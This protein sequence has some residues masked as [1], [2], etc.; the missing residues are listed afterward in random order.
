MLAFLFTALMSLLGND[1]RAVNNVN[2]IPFSDP[3][4]PI[5]T[6]P[7]KV[8][9]FDGT[10]SFDPLSVGKKEY[11][12]NL[13]V[14]NTDEYSHIYYDPVAKD[15]ALQLHGFTNEHLQEHI[16]NQMHDR[17]D[18]LLT[19]HFR[20]NGV[21]APKMNFAINSLLEPNLHGFAEY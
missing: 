21:K 13:N 7:R 6:D 10:H 8:G 4:N 2:T 12:P 19:P 5:G 1:T 20:F 3:Y 18:T 17:T 15:S 16:N 11:N 14:V 9:I